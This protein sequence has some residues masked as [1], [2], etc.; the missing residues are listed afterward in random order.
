MN[1][2]HY[3]NINNKMNIYILYIIS[4]IYHLHVYDKILRKN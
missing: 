4:F 1:Q 2:I 3:N